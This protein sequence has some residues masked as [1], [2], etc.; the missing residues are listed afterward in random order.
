MTLISS[1]FSNLV[2]CSA[3]PLGKDAKLSGYCEEVTDDV[4]AGEIIGGVAISALVCNR[5][6]A[7]CLQH[8]YNE[9]KIMWFLI[10][11]HLEKE[12][13]QIL[14]FGIFLI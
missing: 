14:Y 1:G 3:I 4:V 8:N 2:A 7:I 11:L 6:W 12:M 10:Q 5:K 9:Y 13:L